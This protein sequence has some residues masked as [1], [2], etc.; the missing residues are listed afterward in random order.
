MKKKEHKEKKP[1]KDSRVEEIYEEEV[2]FT[3][4]VRGRVKQIVKIKRYKTAIIEDGKHVLVSN[5]QIDKLEERDDGLSI[6]SDG[7]ELGVVGETE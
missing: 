1:R 3:C 7:E 6:Y 2:E 5:D 4:P